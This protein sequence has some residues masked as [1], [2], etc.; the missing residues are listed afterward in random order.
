[1]KKWLVIAGVGI[2]VVLGAVY[3]LLFTSPGNA[4]LAPVVVKKIDSATDL[5][6]SLERFELRPGRFAVTLLLSPK[7]RIEATGEF[8]LFSRKITADYRVG[9]EDLAALA[10]LT[11][12]PLQG[13]LHTAGTVTGS[14]GKM[15]INGTCDIG[16]G[17]TTYAVTLADFH[18]G[19]VK[20]EMNDARVEKLLLLVGKKPFST[21]ALSIEANLTN[22]D[23]KALAG[24]VTLT[25]SKGV[26]DTA[27][28]KKE[29]NLTL[30]AT[31]YSVKVT[32][33]LQGEAIRYQA[34]LES[35]LAHFS[36][37]GSFA[38]QTLKTDLSYEVNASE[39]A[40]FKPLT[41]APLR[42]PFK[43]SG[44]VKGDRQKLTVSGTSD[45][46]ASRTSYDATLVELK[47]S[48][49]LVKM[50][51]ARLAKLLYLGGQPPYADGRLNVD[52]NLTDLDPDNLKGQAEVKV[53]GGEVAGDVF[54][55]EYHLTL[56]PTTFTCGLNATLKGSAIDYR[57]RFDSNLARIDSAGSVVPKT[58]GLD[59]NY[60]VDIARLGLLQPIA[61][62]PMRGSLKL[63]GTAKGDRKSLTVQGQSDLAGSATTFK[64]GLAGFAPASV[65]AQIKD[66]QLGKALDMVGQPHYA[67]GVVN[68][69][70]DIANAKAGELKGT[71]TAE[72]DRGLVDG[73]VV[74]TE[75]K[76]GEMPKTTFTVKANTTLAG[77]LVDTT[78]TVASTLANLKVNRARYDTGQAL[79]TSDYQAEVPD[80]D[81]LYFVAGRH[82]KGAMT[83]KGDLKKG[84]HLELTAHAD[85]LGG[86]LDGLVRDDDVHADIK[87]IQTLAALQMLV[88]PE[89][90]AASLDGKMDYNLKSK[91]GAFDAKLYDGKF[92]RNIMFDLL[93]GLAKV[94]LYGEQFNG[95]LHSKINGEVVASDLD[96][97]SNHA[98]ITGK[99]ATLDTKTRQIDARL[100]VVAN[101]NPIGVTIKGSVDKPAV[102]L[103]T[104]ALIKQEANKAIKKEVGKLLQNL[105]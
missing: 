47:P 81:R 56:P 82:L 89:I 83:V 93:L 52:L 7:N 48:Q 54:K 101:N 84:E 59:L 16:E 32:S 75:F 65:T 76:L 58:V 14:L 68:V 19:A 102:N 50:A 40:L 28:M 97:R 60:N 5:K 9:L 45:L 64:V 13:A 1:M 70:A 43:T 24:E 66:L 80:L 42:G 51:D 61:G 2:L 35:N 15:L 31:T 21:A 20:V 46:A 92:T 79:L 34:E 23:P 90:F 98:S 104:S 22:V 26:V 95:S 87:K 94:D 71:V 57:A 49:V 85:T 86:S 100:D 91:K 63:S 33:R 69:K 6:T 44:T 99:Y 72:V 30:P 4:L 10:P 12:T 37:A 73:K 67:D 103:D 78:A 18:P 11:K 8:G 77:K 3:F 62:I 105:F 27:L 39:L 88:Y 96:L 38:P 29:Y 41:N 53:E 74:A 55:K 17:R 25:V 36:S